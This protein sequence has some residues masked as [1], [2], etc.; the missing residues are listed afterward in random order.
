MPKLKLF[1]WLFISI[2]IFLRL[3]Q[4]FSDRSLWFDEVLISLNIINKSFIELLGPLDYYQGAP[5]GFLFIEKILVNIFGNSEYTLR[6]FSLFCSI[7]SLF[8][9]NKLGKACLS[10]AGALVAT[11]L[12][13]ISDPSIFYSSEAKQYSGDVTVTLLLLLMALKIE[14]TNKTGFSKLVFCG[15]AGAVLLWFSFPAIFILI[16]TAVTLFVI[17]FIQKNKKKSK[18]VLFCSLFWIIGLFILYKIHLCKLNPAG[19]KLFPGDAFMPFPLDIAWFNALTIRIF[20]FLE[21]SA[22]GIPQIFFLIGTVSFFKR[23]YILFLIFLITILQMLF[24]SAFHLYPLGNR[25][26]LF[27]T[28]LII[29]FIAEG[30]SLIINKTWSNCSV[31]S[32]LL[33]CLLFWN[34]VSVVINNLIN[35]RTKFEIKPVLKYI[36]E[37]STKDDILYVYSNAQYALKFYAKDY[38]FNDKFE[39]DPSQFYSSPKIKRQTEKKGYMTIVNGG[40]SKDFTDGINKLKGYKRVWILFSEIIRKEQEPLVLKYLNESGVMLLNF[41]RPGVRVYL[42]DLSSKGK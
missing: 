33:L 40:N 14:E 38:G 19:I 1:F 4:F 15:I 22:Y 20:K 37:H 25:L 42:Y 29:L 35:P 36:K 9:F 21:L 12:F 27:I 13:A 8:I 16:S 32:V 39:V 24:A 11:A 18:A 6:A 26:L 5:A 3:A 31:I 34:P 17:F 10:P 23:K 2:G 7:S 28:P 41:Q 30:M